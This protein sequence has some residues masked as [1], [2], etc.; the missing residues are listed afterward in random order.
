MNRKRLYMLL[1]SL[2]LVLAIY[3]VILP[4]STR[5]TF[6]TEFKH[7]TAMMF[8]YDL[9]PAPEDKGLRSDHPEE[10]GPQPRNESAEEAAVSDGEEGRPSN[11]N[12]DGNA[13]K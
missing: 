13:V 10:Y 6:I 1:A 12:A 3:M 9:S 11:Q 7:R 8:G 2:V 5:S 4:S